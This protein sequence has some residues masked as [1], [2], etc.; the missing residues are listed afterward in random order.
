VIDARAL[1]DSIGLVMN[2]VNL[3]YAKGRCDCY[4]GVFFDTGDDQ[5]LGILC[6]ATVTRMRFEMSNVED[7]LEGALEDVVFDRLYDAVVSV[8]DGSPPLSV[9]PRLVL[10]D[11]HTVVASISTMHG[12]LHVAVFT[13][14][15]D[16]VLGEIMAPAAIWA[17]SDY[18]Q[19]DDVLAAAMSRMKCDKDFRSFALAC[20]YIE[21]FDDIEEC[22]L[23]EGEDD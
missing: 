1:S 5:P 8:T 13:E 10:Y 21:T 23:E 2:G 6:T 7:S 17:I 11:A 19:E 9:R 12:H 18:D 14:W 22:D 16:T 4:A 20:P 15:G 3:L